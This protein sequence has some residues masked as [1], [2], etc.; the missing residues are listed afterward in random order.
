MGGA[1]R[2]PRRAALRRP[3]IG[4]GSARARERGQSEGAAGA[5]RAGA[6]ERVDHSLA[7]CRPLQELRMSK[8]REISDALT[9]AAQSAM[10]AGSLRSVRA[11]LLQPGQRPLGSFPA[12][13]TVR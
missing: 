8:S 5:A 6:S 12:Q 13:H 10:A 9:A 3:L 7:R 1:R 11:A 4:G 2:A